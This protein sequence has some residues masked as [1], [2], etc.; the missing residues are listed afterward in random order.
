MLLILPAGNQIKHDTNST[1]IIEKNRK[2]TYELNVILCWYF[3]CLFLLACLLNFSGFLLKNEYQC[4]GSCDFEDN[5][6][7][8]IFIPSDVILAFAEI[9]LKVD[10]VTDFCICLQYLT[11]L[12]L[13][14]IKNMQ[15]HEKHAT[16]CEM[17]HARYM[18][19]AFFFHL[20]SRFIEGLRETG[21]SRNRG[22][23]TVFP[24]AKNPKLTI[25]GK[26]SK[27]NKPIF[28][29][30][31]YTILHCVFFLNLA[32]RRCS[33]CESFRSTCFTSKTWKNTK[34]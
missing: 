6:L 23:R 14:R 4:R 34:S 21:T 25:A 19:P 1:P 9:C 16:S 26:R 7:F 10:Y 27:R 8:F 33:H 22:R 13:V 18:Q 11:M 15:A 3:S 30:N 28:V 17:V 5:V 2:C 20:L 12:V 29:A 32:Q 31:T 24:N